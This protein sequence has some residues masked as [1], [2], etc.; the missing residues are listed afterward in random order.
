MGTIQTLLAKTALAMIHL[1]P[2]EG[3]IPG[4]QKLWV[5]ILI[6]LLCDLGQVNAPL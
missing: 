1:G 3:P 5:P 4:S 6:L 2:V